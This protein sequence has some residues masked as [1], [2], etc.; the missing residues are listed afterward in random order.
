MIVLDFVILWWH[1]FVPCRVTFKYVLVAPKNNG[2]F[3]YFFSL[4]RAR[5][6]L[7]NDTLIHLYLE[8]SAAKQKGERLL[9][10]AAS[11]RCNPG[12]QQF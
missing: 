8:W 2:T 9:T 1:C 6:H 4:S 5:L 12:Q 11:C 7:R 10:T 3:K